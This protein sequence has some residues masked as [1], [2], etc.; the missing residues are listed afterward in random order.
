MRD[1]DLRRVAETVYWH[2]TG[3]RPQTFQSAKHE[4]SAIRF[5]DWALRVLA[6][7]G[8]VAAKDDDGVL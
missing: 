7:E 8:Y 6:H 1:K 3:Q 2:R 4:W 5:M